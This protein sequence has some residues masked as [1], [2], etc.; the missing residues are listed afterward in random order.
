M[1]NESWKRRCIK[2]LKKNVHFA[3]IVIKRR[4]NERRLL[5]WHAS[6]D[7]VKVLLYD[8]ID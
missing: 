5:R 7:V 3:M 6:H 4:N 1:N 2:L 8:I